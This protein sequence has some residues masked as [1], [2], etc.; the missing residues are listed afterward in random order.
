MTVD[1][2]YK[3]LSVTVER[4]PKKKPLEAH[5]GGISPSRNDHA[6][7][8]EYPTTIWSGRSE[9]AERLLAETS[10]SAGIVTS[11]FTTD[12]MMDLH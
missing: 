5:F 8:G 4:G 6:V 2:T 7:I 1:G 10:W 11:G 12:A 3:V 9:L